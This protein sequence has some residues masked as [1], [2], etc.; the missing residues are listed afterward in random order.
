MLPADA[1]FRGGTADI[2]APEAPGPV[3][4]TDA[5]GLTKIHKDGIQVAI[6]CEGLLHAKCQRQPEHQV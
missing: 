4:Q 2:A 5:I 6:T 3:S 1:D